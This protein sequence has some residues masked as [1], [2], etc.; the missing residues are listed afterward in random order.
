MFDVKNMSVESKGEAIK[1]CYQQ[2][3]DAT[4]EKNLAKIEHYTVLLRKL[5]DIV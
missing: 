3:R 2:V 4:W 5:T 1:F